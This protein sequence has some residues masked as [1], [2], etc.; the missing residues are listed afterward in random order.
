MASEKRDQ[1][2][3]Q[4]SMTRDYETEYVKYFGFDPAGD[5]LQENGIERP[6]KKLTVYRPMNLIYST[7]A[8]TR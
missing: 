3:S 5:W 4:E 8:Q 7:A 6:F 2:M 1:I